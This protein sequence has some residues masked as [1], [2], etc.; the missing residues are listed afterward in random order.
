MLL[1][2]TIPHRQKNYRVLCGEFIALYGTYSISDLFE[3][4]M[5]A[6]ELNLNLVLIGAIFWLQ[7]VK[8]FAIRND[9]TM[10]EQ[11][12]EKSKFHKKLS[13]TTKWTL[14]LSLIRCTARRAS[15]FSKVFR[16]LLRG[17]RR[18]N[19]AISASQGELWKNW[20]HEH[21]HKR[22]TAASYMACEC[23]SGNVFSF[24]VIVSQEH[25]KDYEP[26]P[27]SHI[28]TERYTPSDTALRHVQVFS[29][30]KYHSGREYN[31]VQKHSARN[32]K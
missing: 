17:K 16:T 24:F 13:K 25:S 1:T 19:E 5:H 4:S 2:G 27:T 32:I 18:T 10:W 6:A 12:W 8:V 23:S 3:L 28:H 29:E 20:S 15:L 21:K 22:R 26:L 31:H 9:P 30:W 11:S 7:F 14:H